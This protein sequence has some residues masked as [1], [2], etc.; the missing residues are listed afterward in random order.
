MS[1]GRNGGPA[2]ETRA[3]GMDLTAGF[4][5][6]GFAGGG[7][8]GDGRDL[9]LSLATLAEVRRGFPK[10][11]ERVG[12]LRGE[13][14]DLLVSVDAGGDAGYLVYAFDF[15][16]ARVAADGHEVLI[17]RVEDQPTWI[18]QRYLTGQVLP[19]AALLQG[20]EVF[21]S[22]VVGLDGQA[23][24]IVAPSGTGKTTLGLRLV[25]AGL[26]L[27]SDDVLVVEP[28][29]GGLLAHP[30]IGLANVR[31]GAGELLPELERAGLARPIGSNERE[32]R[33]AIPRPER[34]LPLGA[35]FILNRF[36]D[37][38]ALEIAPLSPVDPRML[39][40][41]TFNLSVRTPDRLTRQLD[42]CSRLA[43]AAPVYRVTC[44]T[45]VTPG[46]V[47]DAILERA[48]DPLPC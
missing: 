30:G 22:S 45:R 21:H 12:E 14:G 44:G 5:M 4:E 2:L 1:E 15:G 34:P 19:M 38:R 40:A 36:T 18:W 42:V 27:V 46:Q 26:D 9:A 24:G 35:L 7:H 3:F 11:A 16:H 28:H 13:D 20:H 6:P 43:R 33:I 8:A 25:L 29:E 47:A 17:A 41:S 48:R 32:T 31:P 10:D 23:I 37:G 39:L